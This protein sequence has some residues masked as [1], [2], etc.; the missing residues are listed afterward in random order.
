MTSHVL[1][2]IARLSLSQKT[3]FSMFPKTPQRMFSHL[4]RPVLASKCL[5]TSYGVNRVLFCTAVTTSPTSEVRIKHAIDQ[6]K[7]LNYLNAQGILDGSEY[8]FSQFSHGQSNPTFVIESKQKGEGGAGKRIVLR[9]QP[10]GKLLKGIQYGI[11]EMCICMLLLPLLFSF[12]LSLSLL[13]R[14]LLLPPSLPLSLSLSLFR[15]LP[16]PLSH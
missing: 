11:W 1:R 13:F 12:S 10:P 2:N 15:S 6:T 5:N 16:L 14:S 9:K 7:L 8:S 4:R 3:S